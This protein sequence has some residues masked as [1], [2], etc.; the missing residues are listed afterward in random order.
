M[1]FAHP[2]NDDPGSGHRYA[3]SFKRW[4]TPYA[5]AKGVLHMEFSAARRTAVGVGARRRPARELYDTATRHR[6]SARCHGIDKPSGI[7]MTA[8]AQQDRAVGDDGLRRARILRTSTGNC[9]NDYQRD[10]PL[11]AAALRRH[12]PPGSA[13]TK[14]EVIESFERLAGLQTRGAVSRDRGGAWRT[15]HGSAASTLAA[16]G[17]AGGERLEAGRAELLNAYPEVNHNYEREHRY[18]PVVCG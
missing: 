6:L 5:P 1:N 2:L 12:R 4:S 9:S 3:A 17:G 11:T 8:R 18:Q 13:S 16:H 14:S 7:F 10:F 15:G